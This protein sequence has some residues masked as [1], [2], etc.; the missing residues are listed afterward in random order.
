M[1]YKFLMTVEGTRQGKFKPNTAP[2]GGKP[3][4]G[5]WVEL[6]GFSYG[7]SVPYDTSTGGVSGRRT[8]NP[9]K[10]TNEYGSASP[11]LLSTI[12][13]S[14]VLKPVAIPTIGSGK[15]GGGGSGS[16]SGGSGS[17]KGKGS[18]PPFVVTKTYDFSSP[19]L[20]NAHFSSELLKTVQISFTPT[21][22]GKPEQWLTITLT[23]ATIT[24]IRRSTDGGSPQ[25]HEDIHFVYEGIAISNGPPK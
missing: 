12:I 16:G 9:I 11:L 20:Q 23:N 3:G 15:T 24:N 14:E 2:H 10:I 22:H 19:L 5:K 17:N 6:L 25:P 13:N 8:H 21:G 1:A 4:S 7:V 18:H